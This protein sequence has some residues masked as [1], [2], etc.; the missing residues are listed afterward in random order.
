MAGA[1]AFAR[2]SYAA[3]CC[4]S[5]PA[6]RTLAASAVYC[7]CSSRIVAARAASSSRQSTPVSVV[8]AETVSRNCGLS[9][10]VSGLLGQPPAVGGEERSDH[11]PRSESDGSADSSSS[12]APAPAAVATV[13]V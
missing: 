10:H 11:A 12:V 1:I 4:S 7:A 13:S 3:A 8:G 9:V 2:C 5:P 6:A